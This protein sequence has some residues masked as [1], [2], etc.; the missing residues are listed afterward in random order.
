VRILRTVS[1]P[2]RDRFSVKVCG[3]Q[4]VGPRELSIEFAS[5]AGIPSDFEV[6]GLKTK[7]IA[8]QLSLVLLAD[9]RNA[10]GT[11]ADVS[12]VLPSAGLLQVRAKVGQAIYFA[13]DPSISLLEAT[14]LAVQRLHL[15]GYDRLDYLN[16]IFGHEARSLAATIHVA[17][18]CSARHFPVALHRQF[19]AAISEPTVR[20]ALAQQIS[21]WGA[22]ESFLP[23]IAPAR[24]RR[25]PV[26]GVPDFL[27]VSG[28]GE[29]RPREVNFGG[30]IGSFTKDVRWVSWGG[31]RAIGFGE[32][33]MLNPGA[34]YMGQ[35]HFAPDEVVAYDRGGCLGHYAYRNVQW[36]FP[37]A[38]Q[39]FARKNSRGPLCNASFDD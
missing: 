24:E 31:S 35:G 18:G 38:G 9:E 4:R 15:S 29:I 23:T 21:G 14:D 30:D 2:R 28:L 17:R 3:V 20:A 22:Q 13:R 34:T 6:Y 33:W 32:A 37:Q 1:G 26:L 8:S 11:G 12:A 5:V 19:V 27:Y 10:S 36:F 25:L 39:G 7:A 16:C